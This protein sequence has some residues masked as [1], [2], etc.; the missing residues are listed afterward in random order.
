MSNQNDKSPVE[1]IVENEEL[2]NRIKYLEEFL[3]SY[4]IEMEDEFQRLQKESA[5]AKN[6]LSNLLA[7]MSYDIRVPMNGIIGMIDVLRNTKLSPEQKEYI[8]IIA[9][10]SDNLLNII[11][12]ILDYSKIETGQ[13]TLNYNIFNVNELAYS[14]QEII[15]PK[16]K[17]KGLDFI[18][19]ANPS[20]CEMVMGDVE[21]IKQILLYIINNSIKFTQVGFI[22]CSVEC[23]QVN[24]QSVNVIFKINDSGVGLSKELRDSILNEG[25]NYSIIGKEQINP[26]LG[27]SIAYNLIKQMN[28]E[29]GFENLTDFNGILSW[30]SLPLRLA[31][32]NI[33]IKEDYKLS[34][35]ES[36]LHI[37]LVEDNILNQKVA[38]ATLQKAGHTIDLAENGKIAV[39]KFESNS[40]DLILMDI[41][42]PIMDGIKSTLKIRE[43]EKNRNSPRTKIMAVT[44][45]AMEKDKEQCIN[46][47]MDEFLAK[48]FKPNELIAMINR[49]NIK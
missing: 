15:L 3:T 18:F 23:K 12:D 35:S 7:N 44:A 45:F 2:S 9:N 10:S 29:F 37:L 46:A 8:E 34:Q 36:S 49:L 4:R 24:Q 41:Q 22:S 31:Q 6:N 16:A 33:V 48:P 38:I 5:S 19:T 26:G 1:L 30:F 42:M 47:G 20:P 21:R 13:L 39:E 11:N 28:G 43:I 17:A 32:S 14:I 40:Y 27:I 25:P